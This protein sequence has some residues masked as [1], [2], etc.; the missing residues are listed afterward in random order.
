M[1]MDDLGHGTLDVLSLSTLYNGMDV[2]Q[3]S[4]HIK[5][6]AVTYIFCFLTTHGWNEF[7]NT[8]LHDVVSL[9]PSTVD[10]M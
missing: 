6:S 9:I 2:H 4:G 10:K 8:V 3:S 1:T 5:L 7:S